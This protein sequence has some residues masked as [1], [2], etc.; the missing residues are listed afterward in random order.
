M[1]AIVTGIFT[2]LA[3]IKAIAGYVEQ[4]ASAVSVWW[5]NRQHTETLSQIA[6]AAAM[7]S[8]AKSQEERIAAAEKWRQVLS[9]PRISS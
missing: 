8:R 4:F 7:A 5:I 9:R 2:A 1:I 6:D 3:N